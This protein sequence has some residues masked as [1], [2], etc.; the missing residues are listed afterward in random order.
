[1]EEVS[2]TECWHV[3]SRHRSLVAVFATVTA[4]VAL[5]VLMLVPRTYRGQAVLI[6]P[7][8]GQSSASG[9][10]SRLAGIP[11]ISDLGIT[12]SNDPGVYTEILKSDTLARQV[13]D[14]LGLSSV[15][16]KSDDLRQLIEVTVKKSGGMEIDCYVPTAWVKGNKISW[17]A[18]HHPG[19]SADSKTAYLAAELTNAYIK[20]LK[21]FDKE[22]SLSANQRNRV[23]LEGEVKKTGEQLAD[24]EDTFRHFREKHPAL[25]PPETAAQQV[26]QLITVRSR[27]IES[28]TELRST[29][30]SIEE[31]KNVIADQDIILSAGKVIQANP[32]VIELKSQLAQAEVR[33]AQLLENMTDIAP[34]VV[35]ATQEIDKIREKIDQEVPKVTSS[36]TLQ[37]NPVHQSLVQNL[38]GLEIQKSGV[39]ARLDAL[40][41]VMSSLENE[42]AGFAKDQM[43]YIRL[44]RDVKA[45]EAVYTSLLASLSQAK[46]TEAKEP[47]GFTVLDW[48]MPESK[49][50]KPR[51]KLT[52]A[53]AF[54]FGIIFGSLAAL[55]R[56]GKRRSR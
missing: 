30:Q 48:A 49:P 55:V 32:V 28:E 5:V 47:E 22:H 27:Q 16:I 15:D 50:I 1:M 35:A 3:I 33:R 23:F 42:I 53:A 39:Q 2:L 43:T 46:V 6:F 8:E 25:P 31:A 38:A 19:G 56:D 45:L 17:L 9:M 34:D 40:S 14:D 11:S 12:S 24:A 4:L 26:E 18:K 10:L 52:V 21:D 7:S 41:G 13:I 36:E 20:R 37:I 29:E 44:E 54:A 51:V